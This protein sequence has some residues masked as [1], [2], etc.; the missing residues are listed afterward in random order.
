MK[1]RPFLVLTGSVTT[2]LAIVL[3][4][5]LVWPAFAESGAT[6]SAEGSGLKYRV[7]VASPS[8]ESATKRLPP[9][10]S[11][12]S[13][14]AI[15]E[16]APPSSGDAQANVQ[17]LTTRLP[18]I[19]AEDPA[20]EAPSSIADLEAPDPSADRPTAADPMVAEESKESAAAPEKPVETD[21]KPQAEIVTEKPAE[22]YAE[23]PAEKAAEPQPPATVWV[24]RPAPKA[25][26][27]ATA[28][29]MLRSP[30]LELAANEADE[31][32]RVAF[33]LAGRGAIFSARA[34]FIAALRIVTQAL[35][36]ERRTTTHSSGL[37]A[38]LTALRES[39][40]FIPTGSR[41]EADL[42]VPSLVAGHRTPVLKQSDPRG[43][44]PITALQAYLTYAQQQLAASVNSEVAGSMA[45]RGL[46][47]VHAG[48][49]GRQRELVS[50]SRPKAV[51]CYQAA[52]LALPNNYLASNDLG[53][54]LAQSGRPDDARLAFEH[55]LSISPDAAIWHNLSVVYSQLG[56]PDLAEQAAQRSAQIG[57]AETA[58]TRQPIQGWRKM[59]QWVD[60]STFAGTYSQPAMA[61]RSAP[62]RVGAA[63]STETRGDSLGCV[64]GD[65][66]IFA[67]TLCVVPAKIGTV[68][69]RLCQALGP[70]APNAVCAVDCC[71]GSC[72]RRH[73]RW[74]AARLIAWQAY[75]Q[76]EYVGHCR[77]AHVNEYRLRPDDQIDLIYRL[78]REETAT[79][80]R[81]NVGDELQLESRADASLNRTMIVQPD[82]TVT[83]QLL[84]QM[85]ATG[86][87]MVQLQGEVEKAY[88]KYYKIPSITLSPL[89]VNTKLEDLRAT[90]DRRAGI[91]GQSQTV[92]VTPEGTISLPALGSIPAQGL[93]LGELGREVSE[94]YRQEVEGIEAIPAL[95]QRAPRYVYVLGEV[96][97]SGR[98]ELTGPT[99]VMQALSMAGGWNVGGNLHQVVIFRRGDDWRLLATMVDIHAALYGKQPCPD[100]EL[101][102]SDSDV[103]VV[104]KNKIQVADDFIFQV[105]TR[106]AYGIVPFNATWNF[107]SLGVL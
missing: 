105:F 11:E 22:M 64:E 14:D 32:S 52:L 51:A 57:Q 99:T 101:W 49:W 36:A 63:S 102:L 55:S 58:R 92:R 17:G 44:T 39:Q 69:I 84:G 66:P 91:G 70:A 30:G 37:A 27:A 28:V 53:V 71:D 80:Y 96:H 77:T 47:K 20:P 45:L 13:A 93:T 18:R 83:L 46:G 7:N 16:Q 72:G 68:P 23:K 26:P 61:P 104:P 85:H 74:E 19:V 98:F 106:G 67:T 94:R 76:G 33:E 2:V 4:S 25:L 42:D 34:E 24:S 103:V 3:V 5:R 73:N 35:D 12:P 88:L 1:T 65:S 100:G 8:T 40:D 82:G 43:L 10:E 78:T 90:V 50:A 48:M 59:V 60:P 79:P 6:P 75:A 87:T 9:I 97:S 54:L 21:A 38:G 95:V 107:S 62:Q 31:R 15:V 81:I 86:R 41:L 56:R 89:K 29:A